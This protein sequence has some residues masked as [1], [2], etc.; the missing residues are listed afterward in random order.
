LVGVLQQDSLENPSEL[1]Q[2][3][4]F[5]PEYVFGPQGNNGKALNWAVYGGFG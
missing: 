1:T 3:G 5:H 4:P 2:C